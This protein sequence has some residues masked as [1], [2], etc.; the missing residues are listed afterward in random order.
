[1]TTTAT[2]ITTAFDDEIVTVEVVHDTLLWPDC[3]EH[4]PSIDRV[5]IAFVHE[6]TAVDDP[7]QTFS[8]L[9]DSDQ[10]IALAH[11]LIIAATA[12]NE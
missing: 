5:G 10:A 8:F 9:L 6:R 11:R 1:M 7:R 3:P 12:S 4:S 2:P